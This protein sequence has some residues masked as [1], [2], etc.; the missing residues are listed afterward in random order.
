MGINTVDVDSI[1]HVVE[2]YR[3]SLTYRDQRSR[4]GDIVFLYVGQLIPRKGVDVL[5]RAFAHAGLS[6]ASLLVVG[7][8]P[9]E[10]A[11]RSLSLELGLRNVTFLGFH[12]PHELWQVYALADALVLPSRKEVWGLVVNEAVAG[13]LYVICSDRVGAARDVICRGWNGDV[14]PVNDVAALAA[15][16]RNTY[17]M[18][19]VLRERREAIMG[20][21]RSR[22]G[23]GQLASALGSAI[24]QAVQPRG[25]HRR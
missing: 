3:Q 17:L 15:A 1:A 4:L 18:I 9:E 6:R 13:G 23:I 24:K 8:G 22:L 5:L 7:T 2:A 21:A 11:L 14:V 16:L 10:N 25:L 19:D 20:H 12:Q